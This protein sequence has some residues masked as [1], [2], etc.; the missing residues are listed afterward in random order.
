MAER[1]EMYYVTDPT[2]L[3]DPSKVMRFMV[4]FFKMYSDVYFDIFSRIPNHDIPEVMSNFDAFMRRSVISYPFKSEL[5]DSIKTKEGPL[6][7]VVV[8]THSRLVN[9]HHGYTSLSAITHP[10][11]DNL[12]KLAVIGKDAQEAHRLLL[13]IAE[14]I[15]G[16]VPKFVNV[17]VFFTEEE[18]EKEKVILPPTRRE[19]RKKKFLD[20]SKR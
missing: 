5:T 16:E 15:K 8:Q 3:V 20:T 10:S 7:E 6:L 13:H 17:K 9:L 2:E 18:Y 4:M 11:E 1:N 12:K 19:R 14:K